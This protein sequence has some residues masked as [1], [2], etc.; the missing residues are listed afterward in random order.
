[1]NRALL[2][3]SCSIVSLLGACS[4]ANPPPRNEASPAVVATSVAVGAVVGAVGAP[5]GIALGI[6]G[7]MKRESQ[8]NLLDPIYAKG[9]AAIQS[10]DPIVDATHAFESGSV[11]LLPVSSGGSIYP[12]L[13]RESWEPQKFGLPIKQDNLATIRQ[14]SFLSTLM[15]LTGRAPEHPP[16]G[17]SPLY[18]SDVY[19]AFQRTGGHY[20]VLFNQAMYRRIQTRASKADSAAPL[21]P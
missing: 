17:E 13:E 16:D 11:A 12:G 19:F 6:P 8:K 9:T 2:L 5:V 18:I 21:H 7:Q 10:R 20:K 1:M 15:E 3:L 4:T 14:S